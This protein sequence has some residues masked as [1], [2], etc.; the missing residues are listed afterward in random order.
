MPE[1]QVMPS[2]SVRV[3]RHAKH[4]ALA[5]LGALAMSCTPRP[6]MSSVLYPETG[7]AARAVVQVIYAG[8]VSALDQW[9][10]RPAESGAVVV[11]HQRNLIYV[12]GREGRLLAVGI[13]DGIPRWERDIGGAISFLVSDLARKVT[14][15]AL[16]VDGGWT[17]RIHIWHH[18]AHAQ[19]R[20]K[21]CKYW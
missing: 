18:R 20:I 2:R 16:V 3:R 12:G 19:R 1:S 7:T 8:Q 9:V 11:D 21:K 5:L 10:L 15:Q 17:T 14:G 6:E 4:G 13:D